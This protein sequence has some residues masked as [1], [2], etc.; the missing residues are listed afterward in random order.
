M[1]SLV[2]FV[3]NVS[4][5]RDP[6]RVARV[7]RALT[8]DGLKLLDTHSDHDHNRSVFT[9]VGS[10]PDVGESMLEAAALAVREIDLTRHVGA[11]PRVGAFDVAP[12]VPLRATGSGECVEAALQM[13]ER[14]WD[15]LGVPV[16]FYGE[17]ARRES[18]RR[19]EAVRKFGF[20]RLRSLVR[21]GRALPDVGGPALHPTAGACCV[22]VRRLMAAFNVLLPGRDIAA[23]KRIAATIRESGGGLP[24]VKALGL[25]L[26]SAQVAQVSMNLTDL[27]R[28]PVHVAFR[29]V[30]RE[31]HR[32][33]VP[34]LGSELVG[35]VPR[36]ALGPA[37]GALRIA[38]FR[39]SMLLE[40]H[41][42]NWVDRTSQMPRP[43]N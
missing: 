28:T 18:R 40:E 41:I 11:H 1:T 20:E 6:D 29:M 16:Y 34:V 35:L 15:S 19:L 5:G 14:L 10:L 17:A 31:A 24:G 12:I 23:A 21:D 9:L 3:P 2:E 30:L 4:E 32:Y 27:D 13:G 37:P 22:G 25:R 42:D 26:P 7:G 33:G 8:A 36:A 39:P 43:A 38:G